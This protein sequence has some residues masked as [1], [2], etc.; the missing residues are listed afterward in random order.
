MINLR[1]SV[2]FL[3][4]IL[5]NTMIQSKFED[6]STE[7]VNALNNPLLKHGIK[8][9]AL[10]LIDPRRDRSL[11][12]ELVK[13]ALFTPTSSSGAK[14]ALPAFGKAISSLEGVS[15]AFGRSI[16]KFINPTNASGSLGSYMTAF[17]AN[18][19]SFGR[20]SESTTLEELITGSDRVLNAMVTMKK[21]AGIVGPMAAIGGAALD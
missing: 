18:T 9:K 15:P 1:E 21:T 4:S 3:I 14:E 16:T 11:P 19:R 20:Y 17:T 5:N 12:D 13:I 8:D 10:W 6:E 7:I 2:N